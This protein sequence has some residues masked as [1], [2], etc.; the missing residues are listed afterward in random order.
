MT[1]LEAAAQAHADV[2]AHLERIERAQAEIVRKLDAL[3]VRG[4]AELLDS[5]ALAQ[6][7]G[8]TGAALRMRL[9]RGSDLVGLA[10]ELDGR[11]VWRR[12]DV[13]ALLR[14]GRCGR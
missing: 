4:E 3:T 14:R 10:V 9:R 8:I 12:E 7:L 6:L 13:R 1:A 2:M 11:R 5:T